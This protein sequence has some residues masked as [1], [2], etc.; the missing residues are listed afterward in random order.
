MKLEFTQGVSYP[1]GDCSYADVDDSNPWCA[2]VPGL[3]KDA[4]FTGE[5]GVVNWDTCTCTL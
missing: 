4:Q 2:T 3:L 1:A 5:A